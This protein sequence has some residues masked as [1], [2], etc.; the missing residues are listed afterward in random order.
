MTRT[1][2]A[3]VGFV[4]ARNCMRQQVLDDP[5]SLYLIVAGRI[6]QRHATLPIRTE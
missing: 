5:K 2:W 3:S 4:A 1:K 6:Q